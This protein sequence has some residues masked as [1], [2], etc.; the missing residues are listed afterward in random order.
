MR[1]AVSIFFGAFCAV[2]ITLLLAGHPQGHDHDREDEYLHRCMYNAERRY[3][4]C[5]GSS[6]GSQDALDGCERKRQAKRQSC[7]RGTNP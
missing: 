6:D 2:F 7:A 3:R 4:D 5:I 1:V